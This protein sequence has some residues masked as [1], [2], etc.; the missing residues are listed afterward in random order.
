[1]AANESLLGSMKTTV[2]SQTASW[3]AV[4]P[5]IDNLVTRFNNAE[6]L[7]LQYYNEAKA[8][9]TAA[10]APAPSAGD[11]LMMGA[12][13]VNGV[14]DS[15]LYAARA[16]SMG[17][18]PGADY[19]MG[20][21]ASY[22]GV[23]DSDLPLLGRYADGNL[24][25]IAAGYGNN[26]A[27]YGRNKLR[28]CAVGQN[29][30]GTWQMGG[31]PLPGQ[32]GM[33]SSSMGQGLFI[34]DNRQAVPYGI[35][36]TDF[37]QFSVSENIVSTKPEKYFG[38]YG[39]GADTVNQVTYKAQGKD[40]S[41]PVALARGEGRPG[42]GISTISVTRNGFVSTNGQNTGSNISS[43]QLDANK[44]P[45]AIC[46]T[47]CHEF[48]LIT[49]WD[50]VALKGQVAVV[51]LAGTPQNGYVGNEANWEAY[52]GEWRGAYPGL[53]SYGN[54]GFMKLLG[55]V[56]LPGMQTPSAISA[57][58]AWSYDLYAAFQGYD[59]QNGFNL[60]DANIRTALRSGDRSSRTPRQGVAV[61]I[62]KEEKKAIFLDLGPLFRKMFD[63]YYGTSAPPSV[64]TG[65]FPPTFTQSAAQM[66]T[67]IKTVTF[68]D[69]PTAVKCSL[70]TNKCFIGL[71]A[72]TMELWALGDYPNPSG[73]GSPATIVKKG[74]VSV[75]RN[76]TC[77]AITKR[78]A[79]AAGRVSGRAY[80]GD[81][82]FPNAAFDD[83]VFVVSRG[84]RKI[85]NYKIASDMTSATEFFSM[86]DRELLDPVFFED[87]DNHTTESY[88]GTVSDFNGKQFVNLIYDRVVFWDNKGVMAD[89]PTNP[90]TYDWT[91]C[92]PPNGELPKRV[93]FNGVVQR[94]AWGGALKLPGRPLMSG[95]SNVF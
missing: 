7:S 25:V 2:D 93:T 33:Y 44:K 31:P 75:G 1:M 46:V 54:I 43:T 24:D 37:C 68:T 8:V 4:K 94:A 60:A 21:R 30:C 38:Y 26:D 64:A 5:I 40:V 39:G 15:S 42:W 49:V 51:A 45:T 14:L 22:Y 90:L 58:T 59:N 66:P 18:E 92:P 57:T 23:P 86:R 20:P 67:V 53:P 11:A 81:W 72:G 3:V 87:N 50:T 88:I 71:Q 16:N 36:M 13:F 27:T 95:L 83:Y 65:T 84:D 35:G 91:A 76:P 17:T 12:V 10:P 34:P 56:D 69:R 28:G 70:Q 6:A 63:Q 62:S 52:R 29:A 61:I 73:N 41:Y 78:H 55:Y 77:I 74:S 82:V 89:N 9:I 85:A 47:N 48:A 32:G 79:G 19:L 80:F